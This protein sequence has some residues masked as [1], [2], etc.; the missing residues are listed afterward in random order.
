MQK[1]AVLKTMDNKQQSGGPLWVFTQPTG[2]RCCP[3]SP[4]KGTF[5][6]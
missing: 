5:C 4:L 3:N 6:I 1:E 2:V